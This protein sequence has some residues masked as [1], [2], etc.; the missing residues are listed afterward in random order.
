MESFENVDEL[1]QYYSAI[2]SDAHKTGLQGLGGNLADSSLLQELKRHSTETILELGA[3]SGEF[4]QK[5]VSTLG[6]RRYV[7]SDLT[8]KRANPALAKKLES[9]ER[10]KGSFEFI[11]ADAQRL[12]FEDGTFDIV[13][14]TCLLAHVGSPSDVIKEA[15]RVSKP[16]GSLVFL[17]PTDPGLLNQL[18]K[19][20]LTYPKLRRLGVRH[21]Q[22]IYSL[23]HKNPIH[24]L[25][26]VSRYF[27]IGNRLRLRYR[28][29]VL[30][31]WNLNLWVL[32]VINKTQTHV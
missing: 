30:P 18:L 20:A 19:R 3:G 25:I 26:A 13:F 28:P 24:N 12:P 1:E 21:P 10:Q 31:S 8:P 23:E 22:Y 16:E 27:S 32:C 29:F 6:Y 15:L 14:S 7:A 11:Q 17:M 5:A 4:T 2:Y 9:T